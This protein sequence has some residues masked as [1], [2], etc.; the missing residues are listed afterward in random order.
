MEEKIKRYIEENER[1]KGEVR[2]GQR[3][4][5]VAMDKVKK[6]QGESENLE[7]EVKRLKGEVA[8]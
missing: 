4:Q 2:N 5:V 8:E 6:Q 1:L 7:R 3:E